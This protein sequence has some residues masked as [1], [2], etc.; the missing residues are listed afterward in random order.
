MTSSVLKKSS[1]SSPPPAHR[2]LEA[3]IFLNERELQ[4]QRLMEPHVK[5][6]TWEE[7]EALYSLKRDPHITIKQADKGGAVVILNT[8]DYITEA[9]RQLSDPRF[10]RTSDRDLTLEF[11]D[12]IEK[13]LTSLFS[14]HFISKAVY[15]RVRTDNP[16]TPAFYHNP[17]IHKPNTVLGFPP[18]RPIISGNGCVTEKI[19]ALVDLI[20]NPLVPLIPSYVRDSI[21]FSIG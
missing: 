6:I 19:S 10:Y 2:N 4:Q 7:K 3:F 20:L 21:T 15:D 13:Y 9:Q 18:G 16:R 1:R 17:K 5:N 11:S 14:R 12:R 8:G